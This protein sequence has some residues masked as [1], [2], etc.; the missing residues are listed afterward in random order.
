[1]SVVW[2][3]PL[4]PA[5]YSF[6]DFVEI[7]SRRLSLDTCFFQWNFKQITHKHLLIDWLAYLTWDQAHSLAVVNY[8]G[9]ILN[10]IDS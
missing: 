8:N 4:T 7:Y 9:F 3:D 6:A 2:F 1:M 10:K 5:K